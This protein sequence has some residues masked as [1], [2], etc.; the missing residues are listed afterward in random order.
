[1]DL[2]IPGGMG[3]KVAAKELLALDP[4]AKIIVFSG[5]STD[6]IIANYQEYG[7]SGRLEKPFTIINLTRE[8]IRVLKKI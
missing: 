4:D 8:V 3:G 7:F 5:Y 6:P 2:T 1:M